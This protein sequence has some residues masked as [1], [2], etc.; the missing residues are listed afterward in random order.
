MLCRTF[1]FA[2]HAANDSRATV[3]NEYVGFHFL[4]VNAGRAGYCNR[5]ID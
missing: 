2:E 1:V 5:R 4:C 3:G